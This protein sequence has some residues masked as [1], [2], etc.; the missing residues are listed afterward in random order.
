MGGDKDP[1]GTNT[2]SKRT[3]DRRDRVG[4]LVALAHAAGEHEHGAHHAH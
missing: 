1:F 2:L 3:S 4:I